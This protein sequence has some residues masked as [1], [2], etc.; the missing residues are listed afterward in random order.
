MKSSTVIKGAAVVSGVV[1]AGVL[2]KLFAVPVLIVTLAIAVVTYFW[3]KFIDFWLDKLQGLVQKHCGQKICSA[4]G[5]VI[6]F[7]NTPI[8]RLRMGTKATFDAAKRVWQVIR[9]GMKS[10]TRYKKEG[11]EVIIETRIADSDAE[12][13]VQ[14]REAFYDLPTRVRTEVLCGDEQCYKVN[15]HDV[16]DRKFEEAEKGMYN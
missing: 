1:A 4:L 16:I 14:K 3:K 11:D 13:I 9:G 2:F 5:S 12:V 7:L 10:E 6:A 8:S 15:N